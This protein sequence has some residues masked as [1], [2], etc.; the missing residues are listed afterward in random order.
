MWDMSYVNNMAVNFL[1]L[2]FSFFLQQVLL[3]QNETNTKEKNKNLSLRR[4]VFDVHGPFRRG[5]M[6]SA[7][8]DVKT[9]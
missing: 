8:R 3:E 2:D 6:I 1:P 5:E 7:N 4:C 9:E